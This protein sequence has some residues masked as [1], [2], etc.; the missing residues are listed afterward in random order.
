MCRCLILLFLMWRFVEASATMRFVSRRM[1]SVF[2]RARV[3]MFLIFMIL[4]L[5][6][7][8]CFLIL[9]FCCLRVCV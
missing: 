8:L 1:V 7:V 9:S 4:V 6:W 2:F 5:S 3:I